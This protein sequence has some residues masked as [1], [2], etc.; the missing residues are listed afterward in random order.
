MTGRVV[1]W[2]GWAT[3]AGS[4]AGLGVYFAVAGFH[5]A[6]VVAVIGAVVGMM[7]LAAGL[8]GVALARGDAAGPGAG[9]G[10]SA[11]SAGLAGVPRAGDVDASVS[12]TVYG[13][14][15]IGRDMQ[16]HGPVSSGPVSGG[17]AGSAAPGAEPGGKQAQGR[18][19]VDGCPGG[20]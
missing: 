11:G 7:G 1:M 20:E 13:P 9:S 15:T 8:F 14:V 2:A 5:L 12:G 18:P 17:A 19:G 3:V 16:I 10:E 4:A 6:D